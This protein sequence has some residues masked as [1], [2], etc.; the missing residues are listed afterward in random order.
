MKALVWIA[1]VLGF[2]VIHIVVGR[3]MLSLPAS[4]FAQ[5]CWLTREYRWECGGMLYRN[6]FGVH[7][8]KKRLPDGA[9]WLGGMAKKRIATRRPEYLESFVVQ[10]HRAEAAHWCMLLCTP[11][12][13][14]WNPLWACFVMTFYGV[15]ANV[16]CILAQRANRIQL[17]RVL[18]RK[19]RAGQ[20]GCAKPS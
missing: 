20:S 12:F 18:M 9:P 10:T 5:D 16:P 3:T 1:N 13:F 4:L 6:R 14:L 11:L 19:T 8:W 7:R 15:A 17:R 2:P